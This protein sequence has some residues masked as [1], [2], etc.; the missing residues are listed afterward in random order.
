M[1]TSS[2]R[3]APMI[4]RTAFQIALF[5]GWCVDG[6][7]ADK[8]EL[9]KIYPLG[10][11]VGTTV[12]VEAS[13]KFAAWPIQVWSDAKEIEWL[14]LKESGKL[15][16]RIAT[17]AVPGLHWVRLYNEQGAT[18]VKPFLVG[19]YPERL[20]SEPNNQPT[21][22]NEVAKPSS[23]HGVLNKRADVDVYA[24]SLKTDET[25][26]ASI[27]AVNWIQSAADVSLQ[28]LD[29]NGFVLA[30]NLDHVGLDPYLEFTAKRDS[31]YYVR[32]FAFPAT[33]DSTVAFGGGNDWNYRLQL[34]TKPS[35]FAQSQDYSMQ[36]EVNADRIEAQPGKH[37][38]ITTALSV[39][40]PARVGGTITE[41]KQTNVLQFHAKAGTQYRVRV[42][43]REFGSALDAAMAIVDAGGKQLVQQD[44]VGNNRDPVLK[45]KSPADGDYFVEI[46]DFHREGGPMHR[47]IATIEEHVP[48]FIPS[49]ASDLIGMVIGKETE[50]A[51]TIDREAD[52]KDTLQVM[53]EGLPETIECSMA[54]SKAGG[55]SGKKV[56]LKLRATTAFQGPIKIAAKQVDT[57]RK[58][59]ASLANG[60]PV[61]ISATAE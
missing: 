22:A 38:S 56:V 49:I 10:G 47:F 51:V 33:P 53:V 36:S 30:E 34:H 31:K 2:S 21:E 50:L 40:L 39:S 3:P 12:D 15:Q 25:I 60:R 14:C 4:A 41:A 19:E 5:V 9:T 13:G 1:R 29:A 52:Y 32:V 7:A 58:V 26:A 57:D 59:Y 48:S 20:E 54:E 46:N 44:D 45:W 6:R 55:D 18:A 35:P 23:I 42:F 16:A 61:W 24:V 27:T 11:Q 37:V 17:N 28:V 8:P 43:A